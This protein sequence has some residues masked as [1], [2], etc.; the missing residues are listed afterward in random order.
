MWRYIKIKIKRMLPRGLFARSILI[1]VTPII[2]LQAVITI[3]FFE[4]QF[5]DVTRRLAEN[6][7]GEISMIV[8][9]YEAFPDDTAKL[10]ELARDTMNIEV[11]LIPDETIPAR[12]QRPFYDI[13][14]RNLA[15]ELE[16]A[17]GL[18]LVLDDT[19]FDNVTDVRIQLDGAVLRVLAPR[20]RFISSKWH[21][22]LVWMAGASIVLTG[23]A[24]FFLRNTIR[25]IRKLAR[26]AE[27]FGKGREVP[28]FRPSGT[29]EVRQAA[30]AFLSMST[31]IR[32]AIEQRTTMLA[33][34]SHDLRTP[35]TRL[36]LSL[37]M[38]DDSEDVKE[39]CEDIREME[40]MLEGYLAFARGDSEEENTVEVDLAEMIAEIAAKARRSGADVQV[41]SDVIKPASTLAQLRPLAMRRCI[42]NLLDNA[43]KYG[44]R[45]QI[46]L[47]A[48]GRETAITIEDDGPG[49]PE[50]TRDEAFKPFERLDPSRNIET[51]GVGLGLA[52]ARDIARSHGGDITLGS[53]NMGGLKAVIRLPV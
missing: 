4:R 22:L 30:L 31:R 20:R 29:I 39:M 11:A 40:H 9:S 34:V 44:D 26:A 52:I 17:I 51:G 53:S 5:Q 21:F 41:S 3:V 18:P 37:T 47:L 46:S 48:D 36:K 12:T 10:T 50:A 28:N 45:A 7:A 19:R 2:L 32:R 38:M 14:G 15:R 33:G 43:L 25:P 24:I 13:I 16:R 27:E 49:I 23:V 42:T 8:E 6:I 1:I 35:L